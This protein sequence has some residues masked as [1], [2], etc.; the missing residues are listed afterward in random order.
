[1]L[2][3]AGRAIL[4]E[5]FLCVWLWSAVGWFQPGME[6]PRV[7]PVFSLFF[8]VSSISPLH[9]NHFSWPF[10]SFFPDRFMA[11]TFGREYVW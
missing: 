1:M 5:P 11:L 10:P 3:W 2:G 4:K 6:E 7:V 9:L 8:S